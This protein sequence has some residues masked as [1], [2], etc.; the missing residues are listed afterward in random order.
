M[1]RNNFQIIPIEFEHL[2]T[3]QQLPLFHKD[4]FDRIIIAQA[5]TEQLTVASKDR[6]FQDYALPM[7]WE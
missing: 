4:P 2:L 7:V 6:F 5:L 1:D 3:L